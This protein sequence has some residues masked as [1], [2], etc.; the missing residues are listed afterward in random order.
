MYIQEKGIPNSNLELSVSS[1]YPTISHKYYCHKQKKL[2]PH[3]N[4]AK[5]SRSSFMS[6]G[7]VIEQ[8]KFEQYSRHSSIISNGS[9]GSRSSKIQKLKKEGRMNLIE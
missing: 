5:Q 4:D 6:N 3:I 7:S 8:M 1:S 9:K 2:V